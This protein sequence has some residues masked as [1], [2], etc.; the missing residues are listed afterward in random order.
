MPA[1][2]SVM[3]ERD[4]QPPFVCDFEEARVLLH[5]IK[6]A[7]TVVLVHS[8]IFMSHWQ[9]WGE[10][11]GSDVAPCVL[12]VQVVGRPGPLRPEICIM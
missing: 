9:M 1:I 3:T 11:R 4:D 2:A 7:Q 6:T 8:K 5:Q 10:A 12:S